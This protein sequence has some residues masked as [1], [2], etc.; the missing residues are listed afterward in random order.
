MF[1]HLTECEVNLT[2]FVVA[3][4]VEKIT[5]I[6]YAKNKDLRLN[7]LFSIVNDVL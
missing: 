3:A 1:Y 7:G 2:T 4:Q 5:I 6:L